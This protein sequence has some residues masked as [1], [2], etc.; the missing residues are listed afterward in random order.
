MISDYIIRIKLIWT[1][2][3]SLQSRCCPCHSHTAFFFLYIMLSGSQRGQRTGPSLISA[4]QSSWRSPWR[5]ESWSDPRLLACQRIWMPLM[6]V[7]SQTHLVQSAYQ[8]EINCF[9]VVNKAWSCWLLLTKRASFM[10]AVPCLHCIFF[11]WPNICRTRPRTDKSTFL[12][13]SLAL[14]PYCLLKCI[15][16]P[17]F[18]KQTKTTASWPL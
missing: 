3:R 15:H 18:E 11:T 16:F 10:L 1:H 17:L 12:D 7:V 14:E 5:E 8:V 4:M 13:S 9:N 2:S 6:N